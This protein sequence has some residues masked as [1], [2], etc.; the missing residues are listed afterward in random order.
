MRLSIEAFGG[1]VD[2]LHRGVFEAKPWQGFLDDLHAKTCAK[3][4]SV[5]FRPMDQQ[6]DHEYYAG[7]RPSPDLHRLFAN[8][9][10]RDPLPHRGM[11][12]G[13]V[14]DLDALLQRDDPLQQ[15]FYTDMMVPLGFL[16]VRSVRVREASGAEA[17]LSIAG[18]Q[19]FG[20]DET[21]LIG[22]LT[23]HLRT[24]L[25]NFIA[26]ER[27]RFRARLASDAMHRMNYGWLTLDAHC[28]IVDIDPHADLLL[29]QSPALRRT[30]HNRL[31][32]TSSIA[33]Q[34]LSALVR[35]FGQQPDTARPRAINLSRDPW[36]DMLIAPVKNH[37]PAS[38]T[39]VAIAYLNGDRRSSADRREQLVNLFG[40]LPSE[41]RLAWAMAQGMS[42]GDAALSLGITRETARGYAKKIYAKIGARGQADVVR[43]ILTSVLALA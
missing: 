24:A 13:R 11:K 35:Y 37:V 20:P 31:V 40:L 12:E 33:E 21:M 7:D 9:F 32:A 38:P 4:V 41:A 30:R 36:T 23:P 1:L 27:E 10:M 22:M 28:Q 5:T 39:P 19:G 14:Y 18:E 26:L 2:A 15:A 43:N 16:C 34:Q 6:E 17:W 8:K 42:I 29:T 25:H 3:Y